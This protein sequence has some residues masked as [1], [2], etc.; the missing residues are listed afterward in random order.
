MHIVGNISMDDKA[1]KKFVSLS[2]EQ[3][4]EKVFNAMKPTSLEAVELALKDVLNGD[5]IIS[6][7][8]KEAGKAQDSN[9]AGNGK[10]NPKKS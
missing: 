5:N 3:Q 8:D 4:K 9:S 1:Y 10:N 2:K 7:N 6:G